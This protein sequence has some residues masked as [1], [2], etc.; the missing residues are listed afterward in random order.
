MQT[1]RPPDPGRARLAQALSR[2]L[3]RALDVIAP[4]HC[5]LCRLPSG[6][7]LAL[8]ASC[9]EALL[10]NRHGC[11][12]CAL[13][14][15]PVRGHAAPYPRLCPACLGTPPRLARV[16]APFVYDEALSLLIGRWKYQRDASLVLTFARLWCDAVTSPPAVD[17]VLPIPL[18]WRRMLW[19]GFN[20]SADL[21]H[22]LRRQ[23]PLPAPRP[24]PRLARVRATATQ[25]AAPRRERL[26]NLE[27][28][29]RLRGDV[30]G[31]RIALVDDVC[32]TGATA[33]AAAAVLLDAGAS[34]VE[35]WC[36]ARTP[37]H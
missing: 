15:P 12:R 37:M 2:A 8:C 28:A 19:R 16:I 4:H 1:Q 31:L 27:G 20:Q 6:A 3:G 25:A 24:A 29:F 35:L 17:A 5:H 33:E 22:Y 36:I 11:A 14:L 30:R 32:T 18:H 26:A 7:P 23:A 21:V 34:A 9:R 10:R 13:P